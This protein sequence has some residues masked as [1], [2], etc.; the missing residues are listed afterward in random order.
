M[1]VAA[2]VLSMY[3]AFAIIAISLLAA[4]ATEAVS[5]Y[6]IYRTPDYQRLK[7]SLE[8]LQAKGRQHLAQ[9]APAPPVYSCCRRVFY[10]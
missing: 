6:L 3:S 9:S 8:A 4:L 1:R 5:W 7:K 10:C 2:A